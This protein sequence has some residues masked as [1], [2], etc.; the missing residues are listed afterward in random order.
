MGVYF[1][2]LLFSSISLSYLGV[3]FYICVYLCVLMFYVW[4]ACF[5]IGSGDVEDAP[6]PNA[7]NKFEAFEKEDGVYIRG[8]EKAIRFGQRDPVLKC[9]VSEPHKL[10]IVGG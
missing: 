5:N 2:L 4:I 8:E 7:L 10:V 1:F 6:A 3:K 9:N